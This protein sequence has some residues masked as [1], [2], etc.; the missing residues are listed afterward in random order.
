MPARKGMQCCL[1]S[2]LVNTTTLNAKREELLYYIPFVLKM[3]LQQPTQTWHSILRVVKKLFQICVGCWSSVLSTNGMY[4]RSCS[5]FVL[6]HA[7]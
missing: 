6:M 7:Q 2:N 3:L 5:W 1:Q 4:K